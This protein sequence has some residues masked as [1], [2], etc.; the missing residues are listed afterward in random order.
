MLLFVHA[1][2]YMVEQIVT[3]WCIYSYIA[4]SNWF[5]LTTCFLTFYCDPYFLS[6][7]QIFLYILFVYF[8]WN[9]VNVERFAEQNFRS[10]RGF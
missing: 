10:I 3:G 5:E 4:I 8:L 1:F 9:T 7:I 6:Q 2:D